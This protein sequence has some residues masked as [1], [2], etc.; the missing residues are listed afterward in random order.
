[1][2]VPNEEELVRA[3][4]TERVNWTVKDQRENEQLYESLG[5]KNRLASKAKYSHEVFQRDSMTRWQCW[6]RDKH[7]ASLTYNYSEITLCHADIHRNNQ[8]TANLS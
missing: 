8:L 5:T 2:C 6:K 4:L 7:L 1:M 3:R